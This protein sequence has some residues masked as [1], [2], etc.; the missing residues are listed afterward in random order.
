MIANMISAQVPTIVTRS[1]SC[2]VIV[3]VRPS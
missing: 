3:G 1:A 2:G